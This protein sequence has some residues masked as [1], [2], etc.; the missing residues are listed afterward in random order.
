MRL[1][2]ALLVEQDHSQLV[3]LEV[4]APTSSLPQDLLGKLHI[5]TRKNHDFS[6]LSDVSGTI[7]PGRICLL[8]G[9][10]GSGK[11]TLLEALA[12]K[13]DEGGARK[14]LLWAQADGTDNDADADPAVA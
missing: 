7:P 14:V 3:P 9:P 5:K 12:G 11:T 1:P 6:I 8:L 4:A 2:Q 13:L 10:P